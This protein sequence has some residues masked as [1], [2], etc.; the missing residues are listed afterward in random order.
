MTMSP[1]GVIGVPTYPNITIGCVV[2]VQ[3][4]SLDPT[5]ISE[6]KF[7]EQMTATTPNASCKGFPWTWF[8][9]MIFGLNNP[10]FCAFVQHFGGW[11]QPSFYYRAGPNIIS[12]KILLY[13]DSNALTQSDIP[14]PPAP[15]IKERNPQQKQENN[16]SV[17]W[18]IYN[19]DTNYIILIL[20]F[21]CSVMECSLGGAG[22]LE[23]ARGLSHCYQLEE[24]Q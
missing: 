11:V 4:S 17:E 1:L 13:Q 10:L 9:V 19:K 16:S 3:C 23:V 7:Y 18:S 14:S 6:H 22:M 8:I 2:W 15:N 21:Y 12:P 5:F 20:V 24:L